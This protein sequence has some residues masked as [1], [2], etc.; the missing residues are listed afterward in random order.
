MSNPELP[1]HL[2]GAK[3]MLEDHTKFRMHIV[4]A[5]VDNLHVEGQQ[6]LERLCGRQNMH[7]AQMNGEMRQQKICDHVV[8]RKHFF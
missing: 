3:M 4:N 5:P 6:I 8:P 2:N 1:D 7:A